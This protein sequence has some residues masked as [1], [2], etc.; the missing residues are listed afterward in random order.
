[1]E[2]SF[3]LTY[4]HTSVVLG[5]NNNDTFGTL[6]DSDLSTADSMAA[7]EDLGMTHGSTTDPI[8]ENDDLPM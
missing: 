7:M 3:Y 2:E 5:M 6:S 1:M 8:D 4:C